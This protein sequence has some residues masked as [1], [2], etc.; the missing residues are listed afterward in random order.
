MK[1]KELHLSRHIHLYED[2]CDSVLHNHYIEIIRGDNGR[3]FSFR[4]WKY[5]G[6]VAGCLYHDC[7][8]ML[9][10][11]SGDIDFYELS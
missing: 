11:E 7:P 9:R 1:K 6:E 3:I 8:L 2:G 4:T 10:R 5:D